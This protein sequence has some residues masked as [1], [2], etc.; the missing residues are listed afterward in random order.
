MYARIMK[1]QKDSLAVFHK[2]VERLKNVSKSI[3]N[4][5]D[6]NATAM[7]DARKEIT[8]RETFIEMKANANSMLQVDLDK[9]NESI[10]K[11]SEILNVR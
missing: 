7:Q 5:R 1:E 8:E 11:I 2:A 6:A 9:N 10:K 4:I 3:Q